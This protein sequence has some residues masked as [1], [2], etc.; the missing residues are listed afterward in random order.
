MSIRNRVD[1]VAGLCFAAMGL[2]VLLLSVGYRLGTAA[3]MGPGYFPSLLGG[4]LILLGSVIVVLSLRGG[5]HAEAPHSIRSLLIITGS[6]A[7]F[8]VLLPRLGLVA[9][10]FCVAVLSATASPHFDLRRASIT[11]LALAAI[12]YV[13]FVAGLDLRIPAWPQL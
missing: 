11:G 2:A 5:Q 1:F 7:L 9:T 10:V 6:V 13:I 12:C 3:S 4:L 8:G